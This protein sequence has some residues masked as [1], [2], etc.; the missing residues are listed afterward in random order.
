MVTIS[1]S[2]RAIIMDLTH[3]NTDTKIVQQVNT[4]S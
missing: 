3:I 1:T 4:A 2:F